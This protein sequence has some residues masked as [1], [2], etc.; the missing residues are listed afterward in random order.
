MSEDANHDPAQVTVKT[1]LN[2]ALG[3]MP[4]V[5]KRVMLPMLQR[6]SVWKPSQII[7]LWDSLLRGMPIGAMI[8]G[9]ITSKDNQLV[10]MID[11]ITRETLE[12]QPERALSLIDGQQRTVAMLM[13][14]AAR[15]ADTEMSNQRGTAFAQRVWVDFGKDKPPANHLYRFRIT[16]LNQPFGTSPSSP[17]SRL[18]LAEKREARSKFAYLFN[19]RMQATVYKYAIPFP[20]ERSI[21]IPLD[22][23]IAARSSEGKIT[24]APY[25]DEFE[26]RHELLINES[27]RSQASNELPLVKGFASA[28]ELEKY[29]RAVV[30]SYAN[31]I[32]DIA[33]QSARLER[34]SI[35]IDVALNQKIPLIYL[36]SKL[37]TG[38]AENMDGEALT[39]APPLAI[40]FHRIGNNFTK[41][42]DSDYVFAVLKSVIPQF[43]SYVEKL[44]NPGSNAVAAMLTPTDLAVSAVRL[45]AAELHSK[46]ESTFADRVVPDANSLHRML[47]SEEFSSRLIAILSD[48]GSDIAE[49]FGAIDR[50]IRYHPQDNLLGLPVQL[51]PHLGAPLVQTLLRL[52]QRGWI[53]K[54]HQ[55]DVLRLCL[56]WIT[57]VDYKKEASEIAY[58]II[59]QS[60]NSAN[61]FND[62]YKNVIELKRAVSF[63]HPKAL[64][65]V[66][67]LIHFKR[68]DAQTR[69]LPSDA[70][71]FN[72]VDD[73]N[74]LDNLKLKIFYR[75][76]WQPWTYR[77]PVLLWLQ[78]A[79][80]FR[81]HAKDQVFADQSEDTAY[82]Y[83]HIIPYAAFG[84][85]TNKGIPKTFSKD[86][87]RTGD[88]L[89]NVRVWNAS[90]NR[91]L[92]EATIRE[93]LNLDEN[94]SR[95]DAANELMIDSVIDVKTVGHFLTASPS[96][97]ENRLEFWNDAYHA[98]AF[99]KAVET[100]TYS[101]YCLLWEDLRLY[102]LPT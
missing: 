47:K 30:S 64:L 93:K 74:A 12:I 1:W 75:R 35:Q 43:H 81:N 19:T 96:S 38:A 18:S 14:W 44:L 2:W 53:T 6:G 7:D 24:L 37:L 23:L 60:E 98:D 10:S 50:T 57:C 17:D 68:D 36:D 58:K 83:D 95:P 29:Y 102:E 5:E 15:S 85:W 33:C 84:S 8:V 48:S 80:V 3:G 94:I 32:R 26:S 82:D 11:L 66:K 70:D 101:L 46:N 65:E 76:W 92:G 69:V 100:R 89:G 73:Q 31:S 39:A 9:K 99:L 97:L 40:L 51:Y 55:L 22:V 78:R 61:I 79:Y 21:C 42:S 16:T 49:W 63:E 41:L 71:R 91:S 77:H 67:N 20:F 28:L 25:A 87:W 4:E 59:N 62:I 45:V 34:L 54:E 86:Y 90:D 27:M 88:G 13:G 72:P 56:F 52:A